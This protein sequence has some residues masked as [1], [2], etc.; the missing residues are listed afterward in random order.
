VSEKVRAWFDVVESF[1]PSVDYSKIPYCSAENIAYINV[2]VHVRNGSWSVVCGSLAGNR[3]PSLKEILDKVAPQLPNVDVH[4]PFGLHDGVQFIPEFL[5]PAGVNLSAPLSAKARSYLAKLPN[6]AIEPLL[7]AALRQLGWV[8]YL[9]PD[10]TPLWSRIVVSGHS[11]GA[12][13]SAY[14]AHARPVAGALSLSGPQ[15]TCGD[16][17]AEGARKSF[18]SGVAHLCYAEDEDRREVIERNLAFFAKVRTFSASGKP[19]TYGNDKNWCPFPEHAASAIDDQLVEE[20]VQR[21]FALLEDIIAGRHQQR[22][23]ASRLF[24][25][26]PASGGPRGPLPSAGRGGEHHPGAGCDDGAR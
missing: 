4:L 21:C 24:N 19:R 10:G 17:G 8:E 3:G 2:V 1:V 11:Q 25:G 16:A 26:P 5:P 15:D 22:V 13:H 12:S 9:K 20:A 23:C 6:F 14:I 7:G 18:G